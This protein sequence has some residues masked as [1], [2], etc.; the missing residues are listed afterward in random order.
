L[1][2]RGVSC[3][4]LSP[5]Q[6]SAVVGFAGYGATKAQ[7]SRGRSAPQLTAF[8]GEDKE[9]DVKIRYFSED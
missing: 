9:V 6:P 3:G 8:L 5:P 1:G 7:G 2:E 4:A